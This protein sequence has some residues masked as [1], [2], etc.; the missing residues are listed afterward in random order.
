MAV[1]ER[2][3]VARLSMRDGYAQA[4]RH[5]AS[6]SSYKRNEGLLVIPVMG[7]A[8][9]APVVARVH[10]PYGVREFSFEYA[11]DRI[12]PLF[13]AQ[14]TTDSGDTILASVIQFPTPRPNHNG[15]LTYGVSGT[16]SYVQP[17]GGRST[18]DGFPIDKLPFVSAIDVLEAMPPPKGS[19]MIENMNWR[20]NVSDIPAPLMCSYT[21]VG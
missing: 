5:S 12:P 11:K 3:D 16:Y 4:Y 17:L 21:I 2:A 8:G 14:A 1:D 7:P 9:T 19:D 13:P 20:W 10:A 6:E 18:E 15:D